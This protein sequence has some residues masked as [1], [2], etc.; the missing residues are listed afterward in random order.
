MAESARIFARTVNS[1]YY[2]SA[3]T[4]QADDDTRRLRRLLKTMKR[5]LKRNQETGSRMPKHD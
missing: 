1:H 3:S 5:Q 2:S 4:R